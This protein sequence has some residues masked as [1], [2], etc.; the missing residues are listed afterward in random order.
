MGSAYPDYRPVLSVCLRKKN[1]HHSDAPRFLVYVSRA[2]YTFHRCTGAAAH[3]VPATATGTDFPCHGS[4]PKAAQL[5]KCN[6][7][8]GRFAKLWLLAS[9]DL[10]PRR[11]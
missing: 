11:S 9:K 3:V 4:P 7:N 2:A 6:T 1:P 8:T 10:H 5:R